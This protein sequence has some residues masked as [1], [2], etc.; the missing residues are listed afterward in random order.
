MF[1][2]SI[3]GICCPVEHLCQHIVDGFAPKEEPPEDGCPH[4]QIYE[5]DE[6]D[7]ADKGEEWN[8]SKMVGN[9][10]SRQEGTERSDEDKAP[11]EAENRVV[12]VTV[13]LGDALGV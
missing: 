7:V 5:G 8:A 2:D 9:E 11:K 1:N 12:R 4:Q 6:D 13:Q 10:W 3:H